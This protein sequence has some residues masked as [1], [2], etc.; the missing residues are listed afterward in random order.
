MKVE[1]KGKTVDNQTRCEHYHSEL[2]IIAIKFICCDTYYPC[3]SCHSEATEHIAQTWNKAEWNTLAVFCGACQSE[4][5]I[6]QYLNCQSSCPFCQAA[7]NP[8][9]SNHYHLYFEQ[10]DYL[11]DLA[12]K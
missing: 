4:M 8:K 12:G 10:T 2:D 3:F 11:V 7:F 5:T 6:N 9:C 1:I